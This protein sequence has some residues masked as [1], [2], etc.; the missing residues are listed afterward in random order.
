M[1]KESNGT[2]KASYSEFYDL[3]CR[4]YSCRGYDA[5]R[6]VTDEQ[7]RAV[8]ETA[9][10][11]PSACN[12]QPWTFV[13][14]RSLDA[15]TAMLAKSR[16]AFIEAPVLLVAI[17]L[18]D[19]AWHRPSDNKDHTDVDVSIAVE[20]I[21]LAAS[22]MGLATCWVCSFD[23]DAVRNVLDLPDNAEP[24]ALIPLGY[25]S[26]LSQVPAKTRKPLDEI[27]KWEKF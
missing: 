25:P 27:L 11:A 3:V 22:S 15:R 23:V 13:A 12:R 24:V 16:P 18:H 9:Q 14:V 6:P 2:D 4:R 17:G 8:V 1:A 10:L 19:Q 26:A 20:H 5:L 21:C 7:V